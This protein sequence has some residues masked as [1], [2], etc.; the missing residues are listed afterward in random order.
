MILRAMM[1][2]RY[3]PFLDIHFGLASKCY[4][5]F[6]SPIRRYADLMV[7][8][9]LKAE[10]GLFDK[11]HSIFNPEYLENIADSCNEQERTA[12]TAE[13]EVF[14]RLS[15]LMLEKSIGKTFK[16]V[17]SGLS[18][19]GVF[20]EMRENMAEG[21]IR[22][23][24]LGDDYFVYD[25]TKQIL[26]GERTG[27]EYRLGDEIDV[28]IEF[29]DITRLEIDLIL[30]GVTPR[31]AKGRSTLFRNNKNENKNPGF[32]SN[33]EKLY[34]NGRVI[35]AIA[36]LGVL[37][38]VVL[39]GFAA[40]ILIRPVFVYRYMIPAM[41]CF[42]LCFVICLDGLLCKLDITLLLQKERGK[43]EKGKG[44]RYLPLIKKGL[45]L[46][47]IMFLIIG[48]RNYRAFLGE[49]EYKIKLMKDTEAALSQ[50]GPEDIVIYNFDQ[51]QAVTSYYLEN[52]TERY[53]WNVEAESLI[54]EI[55]GPC[56]TVETVETIRAWLE[57]SND[58]AQR[59]DRKVWFI[60]SFNSRDDIVTQ[61][62]ESGLTVEEEGSFLLERYWFNLYEI[63]L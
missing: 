55:I 7:H 43:T 57:D 12:Q 36:A 27:A 14:R 37:A 33:M 24:K 49:E 4:C 42:W 25:E 29:V 58:Q 1:Q 9:S 45:F 52:G 63:S 44:N 60:G 53:L 46:V 20:A 56:K 34:H 48:L 3:S 11:N 28:Q 62:R 50:I 21:M 15:C 8:R 41:G 39:F 19:F 16:A 59:T 10:L 31:K 51:V 13:R 40:S 2:A 38:G 23:E 17:I 47:V 54:Q 6:T 18:N 5:H 22:M 30:M 32:I 26:Y 35:H 61:W